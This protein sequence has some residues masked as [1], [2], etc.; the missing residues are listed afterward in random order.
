[1]EERI[2]VAFAELDPARIADVRSRIPVHRH[3]RP[4]PAAEIAR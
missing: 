2:G 3:R 1:M 4:V